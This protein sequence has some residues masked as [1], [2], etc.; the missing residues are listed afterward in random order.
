MYD[1]CGEIEKRYRRSV[2]Q[3]VIVSLCSISITA[4]LCQNGP[5]VCLKAV[6]LIDKINENVEQKIAS[7]CQ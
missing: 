5:D 7:I 2:A 6:E 1:N 3:I 4:R